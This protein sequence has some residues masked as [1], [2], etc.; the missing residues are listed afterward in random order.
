MINVATGVA[1]VPEH[2]NVALLWQ[3]FGALQAGDDQAAADCYAPAATFRDI[4]F[5]LRGR[6]EIQA[7]WQLVCD[8]SV[9]V[10][11]WHV[12][13]DDRVGYA[14][15]VDAYTFS[16]TRLPVVNPIESRFWFE[17]G[18]IIAHRDECDARRWAEQ[19]FGGSP[20]GW[21][22]G[23]FRLARSWQARK[24]LRRYLTA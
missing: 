2:A 19:A 22:A 18:R 17:N 24:K 5:D 14:R 4:A 21:V 16:T 20:T 7:M 15:I 23:R 8:T 6:R 12:E 1:A 10:T 13:A 11:V 9:R 3:L